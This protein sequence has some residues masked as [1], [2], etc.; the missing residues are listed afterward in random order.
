MTFRLRIAL[1]AR[2]RA[3]ATRSDR[4]QIGDI[5]SR[6][7]TPFFGA[8]VTCAVLL[9][10]SGCAGGSQPPGSLG[11]RETSVTLPPHTVRTGGRVV[12]GSRPVLSIRLDREKHSVDETITARVSYSNPTSSAAVILYGG[13]HLFNVRVRTPSGNA[14]FDPT[15]TPNASYVSAAKVLVPG[16][17]VSRAVGFRLRER[18]DYTIVAYQDI[19]TPPVRF[20]VG[21]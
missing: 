3:E 8:L 2:F 1:G 17:R 5:A 9:L 6:R 10:G 13:D 18:G 14:V 15:N 12:K 16:E 19:E 21:R 11:A 20:M 7:L 4:R